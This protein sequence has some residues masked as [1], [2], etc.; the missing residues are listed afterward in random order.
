VNQI[1]PIRETPE[2][3]TVSRSDYE[4]M[5]EQLEDAED[6]IAVL[7]DCLL[8]MKPHESR[9][10]LTMDETIRIIE[11]ESPLKV[12]REKRGLTVRDLS[13]ALG[14]HAVEIEELEKPEAEFHHKDMLERLYRAAS[15][16]DVLPD[17]LIPP[18][19]TL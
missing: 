16:L 1:K 13:D 11:G 19:V 8:D 10:L 12:W 6:K 7:E 2:T 18:E 9:Y 14:V 15:H 4:A 17:M 5:R 3:V